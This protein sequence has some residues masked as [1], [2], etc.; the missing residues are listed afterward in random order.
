MHIDFDKLKMDMKPF[1]PHECLFE[2]MIPRE[3]LKKNAG[4]KKV[5]KLVMQ[6]ADSGLITRQEIVSMMPPILLDV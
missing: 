6:L 5:H 1:Y 3:M 4:L 2:M